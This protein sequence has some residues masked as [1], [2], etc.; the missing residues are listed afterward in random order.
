MH[1]HYRSTKPK[2]R[3][4]KTDLKRISIKTKMPP[5]K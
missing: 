4:A 5:Y 1:D 2:K 3:H